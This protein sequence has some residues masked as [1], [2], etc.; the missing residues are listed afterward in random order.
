VREGGKTKKSPA[1]KDG[2]SGRSFRTERK[3]SGILVYIR[4]A[5]IS[6]LLQSNAYRRHVFPC[7]EDS[8]REPTDDKSGASPRKLFAT[9]S[10]PTSRTTLRGQGRNLPMA[11]SSFPD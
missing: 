6:T 11:Q 8:V 3:L 9:R 4:L 10:R 2:K 7:S 5:P 1:G